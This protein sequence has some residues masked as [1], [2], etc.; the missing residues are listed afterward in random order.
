MSS[1]PEGLNWVIIVAGL[2]KLLWKKVRLSAC[3]N[4]PQL[5]LSPVRS[6]MLLVLPVGWFWHMVLSVFQISFF[7]K[8]TLFFSWDGCA[9]RHV[10]EVFR[11]LG[12]RDFECC[13]IRS[14]VL[15]SEFGRKGFPGISDMF[16]VLVPLADAP[17]AFPCLLYTSPS[18]RD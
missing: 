16:P 18:P 13:Y 4:Y 14:M 5:K 15:I 1:S 6:V 17:L 2:E 9:N 8:E 10:F 7:W 3:R 12:F 11:L